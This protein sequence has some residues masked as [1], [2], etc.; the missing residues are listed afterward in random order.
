MTKT[1]MPPLT[2][3]C[4]SRLEMWC[5]QA[6]K[7]RPVSLP[8][9]CRGGALQPCAISRR[10]PQPPAAA[11]PLPAT[12]PA[13]LPPRLL[14]AH[15][16]LALKRQHAL[17]LVQPRQ[18]PTVGVKCAVVVVREGLQGVAEVQQAPGRFRRRPSCGP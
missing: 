17:I 1:R 3:G 15:E 10:W 8:M 9:I 12:A 6:W 13:P 2:L 16:L 4:A 14:R 11:W 5:L 7:G 18:R